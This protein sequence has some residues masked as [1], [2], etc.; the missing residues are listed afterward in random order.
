MRK[1][2]KKAHGPSF[3]ECSQKDVERRSEEMSRTFV[4]APSVLH[5]ASAASTFKGKAA[6]KS[7]SA[8]DLSFLGAVTRAKGVVI[9]AG[10]NSV[11]RLAKG[12][13]KLIGG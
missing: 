5:S 2:Q 6:V 11:S 7:P 12:I 8:K 9:K 13:R 4:A 10:V 1:G 3:R